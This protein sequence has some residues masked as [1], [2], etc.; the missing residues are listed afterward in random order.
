MNKKIYIAFAAAFLMFTTACD[1]EV[2]L[3]LNQN[4]NASESID[5]RFLLT[6]G[7]L[8]LSGERY[9]NWRG[10]LIYSST[11]IQHNAHL[12]GY[13]S[14][15]KYLRNAGYS[16]ALWDRYYPSTLKVLTHVVDETAEMEGMGNLHAMASLARSFGLHRLTDVYGD[17][18]YSQAGRGILGEEN[19]FPAYDRQQDVYSMLVTDIRAARDELSDGGFDVGAND[20]MYGGDVSK[21]RK[22]A[23]SLLMRIAM[24]MSNVDNGTAQSVFEEAANNAGGVMESN[25]DNA[26][27]IHVDGQ[28]LNRN[29]VSEVFLTGGEVPS[30]RLSE[31]FVTWMQANNDPRLSLIGGGTGNPTDA[32]TWNT[33]PG[34]QVGMPNGNDTNTIVQAAID[35][36]LISAPEEFSI[37]LYT[38]VNPVLYQFEDPMFFQT[39]AE[40]R[41]LLAE[42]A[43]KGWSVSGSATDHFEAGVAAAVE[44]WASYDGSLAV[45]AADVQAY[46]DGLGFGAAGNQEEMIGEQV[47]AATYFNHY[48][49]WANWRR[50]GFPALTPVNY[51]G[52]V[53]NGQIPRR[54]EYNQGEAV[55]NPI[56]YAQAIDNQGAD[57]FMTRIWWDVN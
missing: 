12:G 37:N 47:W 23:N 19:W 17:I 48:E 16:S 3:D 18:P 51:E 20:V 4:P 14:G 34:A 13:W 56:N 55:A 44:N 21:W 8:R 33:D 35:A 39:Y 15:D 1:N 11:M 10:N 46:V 29:G 49:S 30:V 38:F 42:A 26:M 53:T 28:G 54:L 45:D 40:V 6:E 57:D 22:F 27:I 50:T 7:Q 9:E 43:L 2:L 31:T 32:S 24:R 5:M 36:G 52:N 25:A 41:L